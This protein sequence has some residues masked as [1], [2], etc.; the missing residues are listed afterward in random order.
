MLLLHVLSPFG[1]IFHEHL[2]MLFIRAAWFQPVYS[3]MYLLLP[4]KPTKTI[5]ALCFVGIS[6]YPYVILS[7]VGL[8]GETSRFVDQSGFSCQAKALVWFAKKK[9]WVPKF[10]WGCIPQIVNGL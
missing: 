6:V 7:C 9:T 2:E 3:P 1:A 10:I 8:A 5:A 4:L